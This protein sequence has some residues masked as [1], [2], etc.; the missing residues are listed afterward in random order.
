MGAGLRQEIK[1]RMIYYEKMTST[2]MTLV[3]IKIELALKY[4]G[5]EWKRS[6][7]QLVQFT[8]VPPLISSAMLG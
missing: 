1:K 3:S 4:S 2:L 7:Y 8:P 5:N 6:M